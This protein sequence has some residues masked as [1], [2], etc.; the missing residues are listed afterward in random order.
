MISL[1]MNLKFFDTALIV[2]YIIWCQGK[3]MNSVILHKIASKMMF[4][5]HTMVVTYL[6][7]K[8]RADN[9]GDST[10]YSSNTSTFRSQVRVK[11]VLEKS[12]I[13][14]EQIPIYLFIF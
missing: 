5:T 12:F 10:W 4:K 11:L 9:V 13:K 8:V 14:I 2:L 1:D 6:K 7:T 3:N